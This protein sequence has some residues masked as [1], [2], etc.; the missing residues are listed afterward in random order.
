M[1][2]VTHQLQYLKKLK[3]VVL[4]AEGKI[5]A[6]NSYN[7]LRKSQRASLLSIAPET[8][9]KTNKD[10]ENQESNNLRTQIILK[11][12]LKPV[13][14]EK[15][16]QAEGSVEFRVYKE[17][18][19]SVGCVTLVIL[20]VILR[21]LAQSA[22]S[23]IDYFVAQWVNWEDSIANA[24]SIKSTN[25]SEDRQEYVIFYATI[26]VVFVVI[27]FKGSF[28]F[29][30]ICLKASRNLHDKLFRGVTGTYMTF[31]SENPSGRIL[32]RFSKDIGNIDTM[33]PITLFECTVVSFL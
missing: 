18:F 5:E 27:I 24:T 10:S 25:I 1:I 4:I 31:F 19:K 3:N 29:F 8:Q 26:M 30:H 20:T 21:I 22:A 6:Q 16:F 11:D 33:L 15:E 28:L 7:G 14:E 12:E 13:E 2:L 9:E 23:G 32:N 17:Y